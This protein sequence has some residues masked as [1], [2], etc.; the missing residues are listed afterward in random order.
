MSQAA[1][2]LP[3]PVATIGEV[4]QALGHI[5]AVNSAGIAAEIVR[6]VSDSM[7]ALDQA[8]RAVVKDAEAAGKVADLLTAIRR[9]MATQE[10]ARKVH[11]TP[12]DA[13]KTKL[14]KLYGVATSNL[15]EATGILKQKARVFM[16][17]EQRRQQAE[18]DAA[19][20]DAE[21]EA[22]RLAAAQ[23]ALGD[24]EGAS[25]IL[26]EAAARPAEVVKA[27]AT[28]A[29][30]STL[31]GRNRKVG[32]VTNNAQFL[33]DVLSSPDP[34]C[35]KF[36]EDLRFP[37]SALNELAAAVL[38]GAKPLAGFKAELVNDITSR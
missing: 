36:I 8:N 11:T 28:G 9:A 23:A 7:K 10:I 35:A 18:A 24:A 33:M 32:T 37:P 25:Q 5:P 1:S 20:R 2:N 4:A 30:G 27:T 15:E 17:A 16:D 38:A 14:M 26:E 6:F 21:A 19:R 31:G 3:V 29:Y 13:F 12:L 34:A 22:L